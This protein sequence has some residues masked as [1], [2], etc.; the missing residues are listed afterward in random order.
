MVSAII[1]HPLQLPTKSIDSSEDVIT[2]YCE[3]MK[4]MLAWWQYETSKCVNETGRKE[5]PGQ[6]NRGSPWNTKTRMV[7]G[8]HDTLLWTES[9]RKINEGHDQSVHLSLNWLMTMMMKMLMMTTLKTAMMKKYCLESS[10]TVFNYLSFIK[11]F[12]LLQ[13]V[14]F[15]S[16]SLNV[17]HNTL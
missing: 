10:L 1:L 17:A 6:E 11:S 3:R 9:M 2:W 16:S 14:P 12:R 5:K 15:S 7:F 4:I 13:Y 8:V